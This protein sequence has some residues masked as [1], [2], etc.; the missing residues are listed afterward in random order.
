MDADAP[1]FQPLQDSSHFDV[2]IGDIENVPSVKEKPAPA[3]QAEAEAELLAAAPPKRHLE[4]I[5]VFRRQGPS[6][7]RGA[8]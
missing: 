8:F 1:T 3:E 7:H 6:G 5:C 4:L 2:T